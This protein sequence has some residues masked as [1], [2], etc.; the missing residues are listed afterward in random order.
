MY[1]VVFVV[2]L[3]SIFSVYISPS[4]WKGF[5]ILSSL[6]PVLL[7]VNF[8]YLCLSVI[9]KKWNILL[10]SLLVLFFGSHFI[11][12]GIGTFFL[13]NNSKVGADF[14]VLSYNVEC[15]DVYNKS[16]KYPQCST[17]EEAIFFVLKDKSPI[18][19]F[20]EFYN[21]DSIGRRQADT[22]FR[23]T[24]KLNNLGYEDFVHTTVSNRIN[25]QF[26]LAIFSQYPI[27]NKGVIDLPHLGHGSNAAIYADVLY[28]T[29]TL[30]VVNAHLLSL[31]IW[32][33]LPDRWQLT[34]N[35]RYKYIFNIHLDKQQKRAEQ[36]DVL[37]NFIET[38]PYRTVL[39]MDMND[40]AYSYTYQQM[41]LCLRN[42]FEDKGY[43]LGATL[44]KEELELIRIDNQFYS[45]GIEVVDFETRDDSPYSD[46]YPIKGY[47]QWKD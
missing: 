43:G 24:S 33:D 26:G 5:S 12:G 36:A 44:N 22:L 6:I 30:R 9:K 47:Y 25:S 7:G 34:Q 45:K 3:L 38:S 8:L 28:G 39:C 16:S 29:D 42:A 31:H 10:S 20:Q 15:F 35:E 46:H 13:K 41:R 19:C 17:A 14:S 4:Y 32:K 21:Q 11:Y 23:V 18:K 27:I 2:T 37:R 40:I 1:R